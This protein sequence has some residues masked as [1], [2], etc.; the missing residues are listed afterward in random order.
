MFPIEECKVKCLSVRNWGTSGG[1][2]KLEIWGN[3]YT[4]LYIKINK[5]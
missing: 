5:Q 2:D 1:R 3:I 4:L